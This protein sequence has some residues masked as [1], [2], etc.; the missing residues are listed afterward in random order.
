MFHLEQ[1]AS[2]ALPSIVFYETV[3]DTR[4]AVTVEDRPTPAGE[5]APPTGTPPARE[6]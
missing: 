2:D 6:A 3:D 1:H 4:Y 5:R